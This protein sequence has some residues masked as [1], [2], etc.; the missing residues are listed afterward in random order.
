M[1]ASQRASAC[2]LSTLMLLVV[3]FAPFA[4]NRQ[5]RTVRVGVYQNEPKIF[6]DENGRA[7]GIFID[8]LN[9]MAAQEGWTLAYVP[10][11]WAACLQRPRRWTD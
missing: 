9:E 8:L 11:E 3:A 6:M 2:L 7:S 10:C 5:S 4:P 1:A